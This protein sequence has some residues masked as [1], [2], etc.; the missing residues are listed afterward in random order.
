MTEPLTSV[1]IRTYNRAAFLPRA[2]RSVLVQERQGFEI[3][4]VDDGSTDNTR[5]VVASLADQRIRYF[6]HEHSGNVSTVANWGIAHATGDYIVLLD[7]DDG[8]GPGWLAK[9]AGALDAGAMVACCWD[10]T[11]RPTAV[12]YASV[13][14]RC[15]LAA[16]TMMA[17][18]EACKRVGPHDEML[19]IQSDNDIGIRFSQAYGDGVVLLPEVLVYIYHEGDNISLRQPD[20]AIERNALI[21]KWESEIL[22]VCG[23]AALSAL[24]NDGRC[25]ISSPAR[26]VA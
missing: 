8:A 25:K 18:R 5:A 12:D 3:V 21:D 23:Q 17:R 6:Y 7:S 11:H 1:I 19:P 4:V 15:G 20:T 26:E 2:I 9:L 22:R 13:L 16:N 24:R 10:N 14:A